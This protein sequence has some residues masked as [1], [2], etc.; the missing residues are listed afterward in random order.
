MT[1]GTVRNDEIDAVANSFN[2]RVRVGRVWF[3][4]AIGTGKNQGSGQQP[5][6]LTDRLVRRRAEPQSRVRA[7]ALPDALGQA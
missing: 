6:D 3:A 2:D 4:A 1:T 7:N 5:K